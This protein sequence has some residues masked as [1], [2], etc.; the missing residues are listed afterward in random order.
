L[1][2]DKQLVNIYAPHSVSSRSVLS[3][4]AMEET[5][6]MMVMMVV[7]LGKWRMKKGR[8]GAK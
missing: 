8:N 4:K 2:G 6:D 5:A 3:V 1:A 7:T